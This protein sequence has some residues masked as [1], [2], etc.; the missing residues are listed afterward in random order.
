MGDV[1]G[2]LAVALL[3]GPGRA[4]G[5]YRGLLD[6]SLDPRALGHWLAVDLML[7]AFAAAIVLVPGALAGTWYALVR[8]LDAREQAFAAFVVALAGALLAE[9]ALYASNGSPRFQERYLF[10]LL[11][12]VPILFGLGAR[13][14][15]VG[16]LPV[17]LLALGLLLV[18]ARVPLTTY[19]ALDGKQDSPFLMGMARIEELLD[20]GSGALVASAAAAMLCLVA[21]GAAYRPRFGVAAAY[22]AALVAVGSAAVLA[23]S[24]D[25]DRAGRAAAT[26]GD[27]S[28]TQPWVDD[29]ALR[30]VALLVTPGTHRPAASSH[31][32]WNRSITRVLRLPGTLEIDT[33]GDT[34]V[35]PDRRGALRTPAGASVTGPV[36]VEEYESVGILDDARLLERAPSASL[37][38]PRGEARLAGLL[39]GRLLDGTASSGTTLTIWPRAD[40]PRRGLAAFTLSLP[41][42][43][44]AGTVVD[45]TAPAYDRTVRLRPGSSVDVR[46]PFNATDGP[47]RIALT[48]SEGLSDGFRV[49]IGYMSVP[50]LIDRNP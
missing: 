30:D 32:F 16:R 44:A 24:F 47:V 20:T 28:G 12:F 17:A 10:T 3:L 49:L 4:L 41:A 29:F 9:A 2:G 45:V 21:A 7:L 46:V 19:T 48:A 8:P 40:V 39:V 43:E 26:F 37:W 38:L 11:P 1:R 34:G 33:F 18:A 14:L 22:T 42:G 25:L 13:R 23:V 50:R 15:P 35:A 27:A 5:Y 6:F 31:L 36:L